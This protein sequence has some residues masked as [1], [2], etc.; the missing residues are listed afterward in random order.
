M[1]TRTTRTTRASWYEKNGEA[2][3]VMVLGELPLQA[4]GAG[5]VCV[6]LLTSG[7]NPSDCLLYTSDAADD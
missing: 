6:Q 4:P 7:V 2:R 3:D 1:T 5:E